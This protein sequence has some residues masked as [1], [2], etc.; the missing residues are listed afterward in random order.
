MIDL[1]VSLEECIYL[2]SRE[3]SYIIVG[4]FSKPHLCFSLLIDLWLL[5]VVMIESYLHSSVTSETSK[6][7]VMFFLFY[8]LSVHKDSLPRTKRVSRIMCAWS[9]LNHIFVLL[10]FYGKHCHFLD[11]PRTT[12]TPFKL[13]RITSF[14]LQQQQHFFHVA[15]V[16]SGNYCT[17]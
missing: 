11:L 15:H 9:D 10:L 5:P 1:H 17:P 4:E 8:Q 14:T 12:L 2:F 6:P 3:K 7:T 16:R 13:F